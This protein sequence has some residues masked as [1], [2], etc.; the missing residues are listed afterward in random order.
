MKAATITWRIF[1]AATLITAI[2]AQGFTTVGYYATSGAGSAPQLHGFINFISFFTIDS[3]ALAAVVLLAGSVLAMRENVPDPR[4]FALA[5]VSVVTYMTVTGVV[6]NLLLR[7]IELPQGRTLDWANEILHLIGPV[8][9]LLDWVLAPGRARLRY[10]DVAVVAAFPLAWVAYSLIRGPFAVDAGSG[11][12]PFYPYPFLDPASGVVSVT[13]YIVA[14]AV[15]ICAIAASL[16]WMSRHP[17]WPLPLDTPRTASLRGRAATSQTRGYVIARVVRTLRR[18][19]YWLV[20]F[21]IAASYVLCAAQEGSNPSA[22]AFI[23]QLA[24]VSVALW[25]TRSSGKLQ[26]LS[27]GILAAAVVAV[28][29][30][31]LAGTQGRVVDVVLAVA[32]ALACVLASSTIIAHRAR[33]Q[34][35]GVQNLIAAASA[36]VLVGMLFTFIYNLVAQLSPSLVLDG[37]AGDSFRGQLFFSFTTLTTVGYGNIVPV[38]PV[39]ES[40]AIAEAITGQLFLIVAVASMINMRSV[41]TRPAA[42]EDMSQL[43]RPSV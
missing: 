18:G 33:V 29:A 37:P 12:A 1:G 39:I 24:T 15:L 42:Q 13:V 17:R 21:L 36:Y 38:G 30:V 23:A 9:L 43:R 34:S 7:D 10:R 41:I 11:K 35:P 22:I 26:R 8:I 5:R 19:G 16:V 2:V 25:V 40:I 14:I 31:E 32:S 27:W 20:L 4:W 3:N 6:Y 28:G